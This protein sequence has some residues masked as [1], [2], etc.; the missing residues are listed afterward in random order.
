MPLTELNTCKEMLGNG[1]SCRRCGNLSGCHKAVLA[2]CLCECL[3]SG[4][5][6]VTGGFYDGAVAGFHVCGAGGC[7]SFES[8]LSDRVAEHLQGI[9][10][11]EEV[12]VAEAFVALG[13]DNVAAG[14]SSSS[15]A[16]LFDG[17]DLNHI[18]GFEGIEVAA[19]C[20]GGE[21]EELT[22]GCGGY[23]AVVEDFA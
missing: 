13:G 7:E 23:G 22:E 15:G 2:H 12:I 16:V 14:G 10:G 5:Y 8:F 17:R 20:C 19:Y 18:V 9:A 1:A 11:D 3:C 21:T 6:I 4:C